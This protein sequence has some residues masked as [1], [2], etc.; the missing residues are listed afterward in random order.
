MCT[1]ASH[2]PIK[3][4]RRTTAPAQANKQIITVYRIVCV[5]VSVIKNKCKI[6]KSTAE[7]HQPPKKQKT[8]P[9]NNNKEEQKNKK[10][11]ETASANVCSTPK[12]PK[13]I[14]QSRWRKEIKS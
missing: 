13:R 4:I 6:K 2:A 11:Y 3:Q 12:E 5:C 14:V 10:N 9:N 8:L 7:R 1:H